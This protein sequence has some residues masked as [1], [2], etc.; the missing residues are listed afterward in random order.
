MRA[1]VRFF[2]VVAAPLGAAA[3]AFYWPS[4]A[5]KGVQKFH[6]HGH[7]GLGAHEGGSMSDAEVAAAG[8][9]L[10][11]ARPDVLHFSIVLNGIVQ[12]NQETLVQITPRFPGIRYILLT[13]RSPLEFLDARI[14]S[15]RTT[16]RQLLAVLPDQKSIA[17]IWAMPLQIVCKRPR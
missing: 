14:G 8:I 4:R 11:K 3:L 7:Q 15:A 2:I 5:S 16:L 1:F 10:V 17:R 12:P 9:E 6:P 13:G